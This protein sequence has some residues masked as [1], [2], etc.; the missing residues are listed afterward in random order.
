MSPELKGSNDNTPLY[1]IYSDMTFFFSKKF[2]QR[3]C[4]LEKQ[5]KV[6]GFSSIGFQVNPPHPLL[7]R[8]MLCCRW[9]HRSIFFFTSL[10][11]AVTFLKSYWTRHIGNKSQVVYNYIL[12]T[13]S[14]TVVIRSV[15]LDTSACI[16]ICSLLL[17]HA[18]LLFI[19]PYY[20]SIIHF[21]YLNCL[22]HITWVVLKLHCWPFSPL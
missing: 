11:I 15:T 5:Y 12:Y 22:N 3:H 8:W 19:L 14:H 1:F 16:F 21:G 13:K 6:N 20:P 10:G 7:H 17:L 2:T 4:K 9:V 18:H